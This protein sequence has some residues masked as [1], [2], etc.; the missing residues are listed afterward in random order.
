MKQQTKNLK[1]ESSTIRF[2]VLLVITFVGLSFPDFFD[3]KFLA[4]VSAQT[5]FGMYQN[6]KKDTLKIACFL[7]KDFPTIDAPSIDT[8]MLKDALKD[9]RVEYFEDAESLNKYLHKDHHKLLLLPYGSAFPVEAWESIYYFL[10]CGRG[11]VVLGGSP[12][13]QPVYWQKKENDTSNIKGNWILRTPQPTYAHQLLI[14]PTDPLII[15]SSE[16]YSKKSKTISVSESQANFRDFLMPEIVH[17]LTLRFSTRKDFENEDGT[18]GQREAICRPL[19]HVINEDGLPVASPLLEI[20]RLRGNEAGARWIFAPCDAK[21]SAE[22]IK[23]CIERALEGAVDF[24]IRPIFASIFKGEIPILRVNLHKPNLSL[25]STRIISAHVTVTDSKNKVV[26]NEKINLHGTNEFLTE[27]ISIQTKSKLSPGYYKVKVELINVNWH[28]N[29]VKSGFWVWDKS[30]LEPSPKLTVTKDWI[31]RDGK[32]FPIIGTTY[33][34]SDVHRKFL[35]EPNPEIWDKDFAMMKKLGINF[36]RTGIWTGWYRIMLDAGAIDESFLRALDAFVLTAAKYDILLCFNFFAFTPPLNGATNPYIDPRALHWQKT[37][38]TLIV[39]RYKDF[40]WIHYDLINE[41]SYSP[42]ND[43]WKN[44]PINDPYEKSAWIEWVKQKHGDD[45]SVIRDRWRESGTDIFSIPY[46]DELSYRRV[47]DYRRPRKALDFQLFTQDVLKLWADSLR[48][49][50]KSIAP[51]TLIT[52]GQDEGGT[53]TRPSQQFHYSAVDY[54]SIHTWWQN[55]DLLY[56]AAFTKVPEKPN[57]VSETGIMRIENIDGEPWLTPSAAQKLLEK[58]FA[59]AF[60]GRSAGVMQWAWNINPYQPIDN[61]SVIGLFRP[62]GTAKI[63]INVLKDFAQFFNKAKIHLDDFEPDPVIVIIPHSKIFSSRPYGTESVRRITRLFADHFSIVPTLLSEYKIDSA[64]IS[65]VKLIIIPSAEMLDDSA[66]EVIFK[67]SQLGIKILFTGSVEGNS[68]GI[69]SNSFKKL[70]IEHQSEPV[71]YR[72]FTHW[73]L[74]KVNEEIPVTFDRGQTEFLKKSKAAK[75][76]STDQLILHESLPLELAQEKEPFLSLI[77]T[78]LKSA[79]MESGFSAIPLTTRVLKTKN[80]A[81]VICMNETNA[82]LSKEIIID[83]FNFKITLAAE[84][85]KLFVIDRKTGKI[86]ISTGK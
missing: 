2:L 22:N 25:D 83:K 16:F 34:A 5:E 64:R 59:L 30:L 51:N 26:F 9:F 55:D 29:V 81:L 41:P 20:D 49:V 8:L 53:W 68:F 15:N 21:L 63:E 38:I 50:I 75:L 60:A 84:R 66:S 27:N 82:E 72:E 74:S 47:R 70:G 36:V 13:H 57:L 80:R 39:K 62:D 4:E 14:G 42:P 33:M 46:E 19:V 10:L 6:N 3:L 31:R 54:T 12:F 76:I 44:T 11:L 1:K 78:V 86:L 73:T 28:P 18:S 52:L 7:S 48:N 23:N 56:D 69:I 85:S 24:S 37:F 58:K 32:V 45:Q 71:S 77:E 67:A 79:G 40:Q 43:L 35:F 61:E 65:S 17:A